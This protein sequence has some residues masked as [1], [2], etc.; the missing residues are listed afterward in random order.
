MRNGEGQSVSFKKQTASEGCVLPEVL[1]AEQ[2]SPHW[3]PSVEQIS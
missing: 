3:R 2:S 1:E